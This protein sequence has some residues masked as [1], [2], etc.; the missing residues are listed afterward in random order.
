MLV[1]GGRFKGRCLLKPE[2]LQL[3]FTGQ[4]DGVDDSSLAEDSGQIPCPGLPFGS[5]ALA[6]GS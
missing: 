5:I 3:M 4:L 2:T 1:D 6:S